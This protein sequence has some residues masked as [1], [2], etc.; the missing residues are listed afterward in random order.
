MPLLLSKK[1]IRV[2][3]GILG[4]APKGR[5]LAIE[6]PR[7]AKALDCPLGLEQGTDL[8]ELEVAS[9]TA[10]IIDGVTRRDDW[11]GAA[12]ALQSGGL[13]ISIDRNAKEASTRLLCGGFSDIRQVPVGRR[14]VSV[15]VRL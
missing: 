10:I 15:G 7:L 2:V 1:L 12:S 13:M 5:G 8:A 3:D 11:A 9:C 14:L 4:E 6:L